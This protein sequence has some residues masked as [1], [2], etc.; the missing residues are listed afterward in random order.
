M[1]ELSPSTYFARKKRPQPARR[2]GTNSLIPPLE[3]V[4]A[5]PGG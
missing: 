5:E 1:P 3:E 2:R 4:H